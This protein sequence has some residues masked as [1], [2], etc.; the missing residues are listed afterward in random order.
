MEDVSKALAD[1]SNKSAPGP[2]GIGYKLLKWAHA[3]SP[4]RLPHLFNSSIAL[5]Y[6]PWKE[7]TVIPIPK[8]NKPDY[9]L[10]KA[11]RPVSLMECCGKLLEKIVA[12]RILLDTNH[13][14][15]LP[16]TQFGSRDYHCTTDACL[17]LVHSVQSCTKAGYVAAA[18][19]FDIQG[20]FDNLHVDRLIHLVRI[21]GFDPLLCSW[22]CSFLTDRRVSLSFNGDTLDTLTLDHSTPQGSP[23]SPILS[24]IYTLPLLWLAEAWAFSSLA[25]YVDD[26]NILATGS[27]F[28]AATTCCAS[29]FHTVVTWLNQNGLTIDADKTEYITFGPRRSPELIG[30]PY[31]GVRLKVPSGRVLSV[32]RSHTVQYL[33]VFITKKFDWRPHIKIMA[34]HARSTIRTLHVLSNSVWGLDFANWRRTFHAII[35][36]VLTYSLPLWSHNLPKSLI[37]ILQVAQND[38]VRQLSGTFKTTPIEPLHNMVAI[39][40]IHFL[41]PKLCLQACNRIE[42]LPPTHCL[43]TLPNADTSRFHPP[44]T[45]I[46]TA[47]TMLLPSSPQPFYLLSHCMWS[48]PQVMSS[49][50]HPKDDK[51]LLAVQAWASHSTVNSTSIYIYPLPHP[52]AHTFAFLISQDDSIVDQGFSIDHSTTHAYVH[53]TILVTQAL[54]RLPKHNT[55]LFLPSCNLHNPLLS[56]HKHKHLPSASVFTLTLQVFLLLHLDIYFTLLHLPTQLPKLPAHSPCPDLCTFPCNWPGPLWKDHVLNKLRIMASQSDISPPPNNPK[57]LAFCLWKMEYDTHPVPCKWAHN[58]IVPIPMSPEPPPFMAGALSLEQ[59]HASSLVL[60]V[61]FKHCFSGDFSYAHRPGARDNT[62]C[63]CFPP[64][65]SI[66]E[67]HDGEAWVPPELDQE[68]ISS[69]NGDLCLY[70]GEDRGPGFV[71]LM[72][73]FLNPNPPT[74]PRSPSPRPYRTCHCKRH[75][76]HPHSTSHAVFSCPYISALQREILGHDPSPHTLFHTFK[77]AIKLLTFLF[78]S[79]SLLHP[80]P[81]CPDPP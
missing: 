15:L 12:R 18:I 48:H 64:D 16:P 54:A 76:T 58:T 6:H 8:P 50:T 44:F 81:P 20:F 9:R 77:G 47:L 79:N 3:A 30:S 5:S 2:L 4:S 46:P 52:H 57:M 17:S 19:L 78:A 56:L 40:P 22:V 41:I 55:A 71:C 26:G 70:N 27:T 35:L 73:E 37:H 51:L 42:R 60:Q 28:E 25:F 59:R 34:A 7:A 23:L 68:C 65:A 43:L 74:N 72:E 10:A 21:L 33:G 32:H 75:H 80:L 61:F 11:Y 14:Q 67:T 39:P 13:Y 24:A 29:R 63:E 1:T 53:T 62:T 49:L 66:D 36:P 38:A 31:H 69:G 45:T